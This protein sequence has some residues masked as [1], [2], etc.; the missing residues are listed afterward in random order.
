M[1]G[2]P[3]SSSLLSGVLLAESLRLDAVLTTDALRVRRVWRADAGDPE[4]GQPSLWTFLEFDVA[5]DDADRL[6]VDLRDVLSDV[7]GWYCSFGSTTEMIVVF[8]DRIFRYRRG[9]AAE[10]AA[11]EAHARSLGVPEAQ[12]DWEG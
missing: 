5:E 9:D 4:A 6:A 1:D 2:G 10:R 12:L 7:G 8:A 11:V 3:A